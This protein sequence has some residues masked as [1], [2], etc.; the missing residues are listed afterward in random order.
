MFRPLALTPSRGFRRTTPDSAPDQQWYAETPYQCSKCGN[1]TLFFRRER[2]LPDNG[3]AVIVSAWIC[4]LCSK[5][6]WGQPR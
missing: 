3:S 5:R 4:P 1:D 6:H 2:C